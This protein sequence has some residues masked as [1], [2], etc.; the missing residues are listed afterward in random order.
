M[1]TRLF[2]CPSTGHW[3]QA[4]FVGNGSVNGDETYEGVT[5]L[6][7]QVHMVNPKTGKVLGAD[8][9]TNRPTPHLPPWFGACRCTGKKKAPGQPGFARVDHERKSRDHGALDVPI[10]SQSINQARRG[11]RKRPDPPLD[12]TG[13]EGSYSKRA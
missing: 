5:C 2:L 4:W 1:A 8:E 3:V 6:S 9:E 7:L 13:P 12:T 10:L 11:S